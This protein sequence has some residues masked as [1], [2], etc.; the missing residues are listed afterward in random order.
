MYVATIFLI[1]V[2]LMMIMIIE[3][4]MTAVMVNM[5]RYDSLEVVE[6]DLCSLLSSVCI[7]M[8]AQLFKASVL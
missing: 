1:M 8:H 6:M 5:Y 7:Q 3:K 2:S 4:M